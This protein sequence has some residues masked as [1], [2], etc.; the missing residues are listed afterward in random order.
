MSEEGLKNYEKIAKEQIRELN[1]LAKR[2]SRSSMTDEK[3]DEERSK[4]RL[5]MQKYRLEKSK[6]E[7]EY[8]NIVEKHRKR[9]EREARDDEKRMKDNLRAKNSMNQFRENLPSK[10]IPRVKKNLTEEEDWKTFA[11]SNQKSKELLASRKPQMAEYIEKLKNEKAKSNEEKSNWDQVVNK[12]DKD[13]EEKEKNKI[14]R[15]VKGKECTCSH[16]FSN[17]LFCQNQVQLSDQNYDSDDC[18]CKLPDWTKEELEKY[19]RQSFEDWKEWRKKKAREK[20][21]ENAKTLKRKLLQPIIMPKA[22]PSEYE[23]I[24][25]INIRQRKKEWEQLEKQWDADNK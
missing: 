24:R 17:C 23:R 5:R 20:K 3:K 21:Q 10:Y 15:D 16:D 14:Q 7:C 12:S 6:E 1:R 19:E 25:E 2:I 18:G 4:N 11:G 13:M 9:K 8:D 22:I